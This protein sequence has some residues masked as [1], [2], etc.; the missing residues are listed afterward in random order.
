MRRH[1][2]VCCI[3]GLPTQVGGRLLDCLLT[4]LTCSYSLS[5]SGDWVIVFIGFDCGGFVRQT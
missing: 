3:G 5:V 1:P 4:V 2:F